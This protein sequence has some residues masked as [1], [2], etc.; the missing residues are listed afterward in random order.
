LDVIICVFLV[1]LSMGHGTNLEQYANSMGLGTKI[2]GSKQFSLISISQLFTHH[3]H[4]GF[5]I[6]GFGN[7]V[8]QVDRLLSAK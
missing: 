2:R 7:I 8:K 1:D 3:K 5:I 6:T 4:K